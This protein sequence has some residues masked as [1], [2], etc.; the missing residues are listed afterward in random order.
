MRGA[1]GLTLVEFLFATS[2]IAFV[3]LG[4][5]GMFPTALRNV[6]VGGHTSKASVLAMQMAEAIRNDQF[7]LLIGRYHGF[8]TGSLSSLNCLTLAPPT[9]FDVSYTKKKW[10]C[11]LRATGGEAGGKGLPYGTGSVTVTCRNPDGSANNSS[12]CATGLVRVTV[13]V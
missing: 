1:A 11:D 6:V 13:T 5:A 7:E 9:S 2:V 4:V 8:G 3:L 12:P 10:A